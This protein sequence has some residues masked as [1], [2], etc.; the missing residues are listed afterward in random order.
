[1]ARWNYTITNGTALREAIYE[2]DA[3][4]VVER[5]IKCYEELLK[6]LNDEDRNWKEY[7]IEDS[8]ETL[9]LYDVASDDEDNVND[10]LD[11]FYAICD[12]VGAFVAL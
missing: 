4:K 1:M 2:D 12:D 8:I 7:D 10:Y 11:E 6:K 9:K 5:L 3:E